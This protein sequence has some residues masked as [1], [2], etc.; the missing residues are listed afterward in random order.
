MVKRARTV[1]DKMLLDELIPPSSAKAAQLFL[2]DMNPSGSHDFQSCD[3]LSRAV[4]YL[5]KKCDTADVKVFVSFMTDAS[6]AGASRPALA[7]EV[8]SINYCL[9]TLVDFYELSYV[10]DPRSILRRQLCGQPA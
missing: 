7:S 5:K 8:S 1:F 4:S 2:E 9:H 10:E 3:S 6:G